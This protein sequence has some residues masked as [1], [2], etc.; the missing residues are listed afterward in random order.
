MKREALV[1]LDNELLDLIRGQQQRV[2]DRYPPGT[3]LLPRPERTRT[4]S[5]GQQRNLP[6]GALPLAGTLRR[7]Q[8]A[9]PARHLTPHQW[10]HT[11]GTILINRDVP[12]HVVQKI[13]DHD[14]AEMTAHYARLSRSDR[15]RALGK[16]PP[17]STPQ[18]RPVP[19]S[20]DGPLSDAAWS[21]QRL[22]RATPAL[23]RRLLPACSRGASARTRTSP[24]PMFVTTAE[25]FPQHHAQRQRDAADHHRRRGERAGPRSPR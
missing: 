7:P 25:P 23:P 14:S 11:L 21:K 6:P 1:P 18:G 12:R 15:P 3:V 8:R 16:D 4:G 9:Q 10:R 22:S 17:R 24:C 13:L 19:I 20:P 2:L 5:P